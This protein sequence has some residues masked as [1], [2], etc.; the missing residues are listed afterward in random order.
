VVS[1]TDSPRLTRGVWTLIALNA[2]MLFLQVIVLSKKFL[3]DGLG[4]SWAHRAHWWSLVTYTFVHVSVLHLAVNMYALAI[5]GPRLEYAWGTRRLVYF[6][7][8]G[9]LGGVAL[10]AIFVRDGT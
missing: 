4:F 8:A 3:F 7:F 6:Y 10:H 9:G 1:A 5:F 2:A